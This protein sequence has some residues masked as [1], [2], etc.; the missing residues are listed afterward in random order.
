R[1]INAQGQE[2]PLQ[3]AQDGIWQYQNVALHDGSMAT[4]E[5]VVRFYEAGGRYIADGPYAGDGRHSPLKSGLVSSFTL[6]DQERADLIAFLEALTDTTF[7]T[8]PRFSDPFAAEARVV[9]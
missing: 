1:L 2:V 9:P 8:D 5:E 6:T 7:I 3:L 4:L